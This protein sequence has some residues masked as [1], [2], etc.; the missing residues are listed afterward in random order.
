MMIN[1]TLQIHVHSIRT[2]NKKMPDHYLSPSLNVWLC[3]VLLKETLQRNSRH[4][5]KRPFYQRTRKW[6]DRRAHSLYFK[7]SPQCCSSGCWSR[8][9]TIA[10]EWLTYQWY[11][12]G[13]YSGGWGGWPWQR[14]ATA[15]SQS[16]VGMVNIDQ[17]EAREDPEEAVSREDERFMGRWNKM[18]AF[19]CLK[20]SVSRW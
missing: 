3:Y 19:G 16:E 17:S 10:R 11:W 13:S 6:T 7:G 20:W 12:R 14:T 1:R 2:R 8:S 18:E 5:G 4:T 9:R 15:V